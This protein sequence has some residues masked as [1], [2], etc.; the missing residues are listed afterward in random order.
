MGHYS[1]VYFGYTAGVADKIEKLFSK[2]IGQLPE[3]L[4]DNT[5]WGQYDSNNIS[6]YG[7]GY[8]Y[9]L[10]QIMSTKRTKWYQSYTPE[11]FININIQAMEEDPV[12]YPPEE[13][14]FIIIGESFPADLTDFK[15]AGQLNESIMEFRVEVADFGTASG[16]YGFTK[17]K[18]REE[19]EKDMDSLPAHSIGTIN[20]TYIEEYV[21]YY[22]LQ[23]RV[24]PVDEYF[25]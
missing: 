13:W 2:T 15:Y 16:S 12:T 6:A 23:I 18:D 5:I 1:D 8:Q 3:E 10:W 14:F 17:S 9:P 19:F 22:G 25:S 7:G 24:E 4:F 21:D 11:G 20:Y